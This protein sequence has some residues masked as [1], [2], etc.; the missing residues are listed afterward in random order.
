MSTPR[1]ELRPAVRFPPPFLFIAGLVL[2]WLLETRVVRLRLSGNIHRIHS[3]EGIGTAFLIAGLFLMAWAFL[4]FVRLGTG[5][6]PGARATRIVSHGPY[7]YS[8]NPMYT[9]MALA[10]FGGAFIMNSVWILITLPV[11]I[12]AL[13]QLVISREESYLTEAFPEE[14]PEYQA[15]VRR[16]I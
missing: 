1:A 4:I 2:A 3:L 7:R 14:Y 16:F 13:Y 5:I 12:L 6:L 8:R 15:R 9:G 11:V 10:C